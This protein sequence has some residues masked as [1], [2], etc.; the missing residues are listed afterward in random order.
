MQVRCPVCNRQQEDNGKR[1]TCER[2]GLS[3]M[4]SY[5]YPNNSVFHPD[6]PYPGEEKISMTVDRVYTQLKKRRAAR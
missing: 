1:N 5:D 2:C 4:P 6:R 3:P